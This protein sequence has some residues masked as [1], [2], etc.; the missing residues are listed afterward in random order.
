M[1]RELAKELKAAKFPQGWDCHASEPSSDD[2]LAQIASDFGYCSWQ[3]IIGDMVKHID[4]PEHD[5]CESLARFWML[6]KA[7]AGA[8]EA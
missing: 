4:H 5:L 1:N 6:L 7:N 3:D 2:L 8:L